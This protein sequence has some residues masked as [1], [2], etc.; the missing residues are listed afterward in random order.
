MSIDEEPCM[1]GH[2]RARHY[3]VSKDGDG[4]GR[5]ALPFCDCTEFRIDRA[6]KMGDSNESED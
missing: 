6:T 3:D 2:P 5:C 1:C 4:L